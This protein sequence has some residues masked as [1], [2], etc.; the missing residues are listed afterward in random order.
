MH[1]GLF[2]FFKRFICAAPRALDPRRPRLCLALFP[3][4]TH[5]RTHAHTHNAAS[6]LTVP[7]PSGG[8]ETVTS[9]H[10]LAPPLHR[11]RPRGSIEASIT[12]CPPPSPFTC[13][14]CLS[15]STGGNRTAT[16]GHG[17][18]GGA[19]L[20]SLMGRTKNWPARPSPAR[21]ASAPCTP[22]LSAPTPWHTS[23][24]SRGHAVCSVK[25]DWW[26]SVGRALAARPA[27][28]P[29]G[30]ACWAAHHPVR[31]GGGGP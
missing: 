11:A 21:R 10:R 19:F 15:P 25:K 1:E 29:S 27:A 6:F 5:A 4:H 17:A 24:V 18:G 7:P 13:P 8:V 16:C 28:R 23:M 20:D 30:P 22:L 31:H 12:T 9:P 2:F 14:S 3:T 26:G